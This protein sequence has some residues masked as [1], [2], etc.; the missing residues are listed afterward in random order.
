[1]DHHH[2]YTMFVR[3][4]RISTENG[5]FTCE[6]EGA[7]GRSEWFFILRLRRLYSWKMFEL[8]VE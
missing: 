8:L 6:R 1:M 4:G 3:W 5:D 7:C 2:R